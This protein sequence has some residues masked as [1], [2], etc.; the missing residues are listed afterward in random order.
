MKSASAR[1]VGTEDGA[2]FTPKRPYSEVV[3][4]PRILFMTV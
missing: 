3:L 4:F 1:G 2:R